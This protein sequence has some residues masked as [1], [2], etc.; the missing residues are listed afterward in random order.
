MRRREFIKRRRDNES[1]VITRRKQ[2]VRAVLV[3]GR[4]HTDVAREFKTTPNT[5]GKWVKRFFEEGAD[6]LVNRKRSFLT[7]KPGILNRWDLIKPYLDRRQ[8]SF[9]AAAEAT[10][11]GRGGCK[12]LAGITKISARP[13]RIESDN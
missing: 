3:R 10:V 11:I 1:L 4:Q 9:W 2:I 7:A 8:Q 13:Y 12:L 5:V 6:G